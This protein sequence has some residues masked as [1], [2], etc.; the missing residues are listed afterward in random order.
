MF[1]LKNKK[2][3]PI[4]YGTIFAGIF[5][6]IIARIVDY[7]LWPV[8]GFGA[9]IIVGDMIAAH[10]FG[11]GKI[12]DHVMDFGLFIILVSITFGIILIPLIIIF[13]PPLAV[14]EAIEAILIFFICAITMPA[15]RYIRT[16]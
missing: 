10:Y 8:I 13:D 6:I 7:P 12:S 16:R 1:K 4:L 3:K 9:G 5:L 15:I 14:V 2:D 11:L